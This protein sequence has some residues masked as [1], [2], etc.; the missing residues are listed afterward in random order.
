[1]WKVGNWGFIRVQISLSRNLLKVHRTD[2][3]LYDEGCVGGLFGFS[4]G[5]M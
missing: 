3:G 4:I 1:M 2:I 5:I